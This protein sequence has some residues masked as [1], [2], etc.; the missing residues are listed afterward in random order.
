MK[1]F[2]KKKYSFF[3]KIPAGIFFFIFID[4][5]ATNFTPNSFLDKKNSYHLKTN[6]DIKSDNLPL[7][8]FEDK[9]TTLP[10]HKKE[11]SL[12]GNIS[13]D[14]YYNF[15]S[16]KIG[17]LKE[18]SLNINMN[19]GFIQTWYHANRDFDTLLHTSNIGQSVFSKQ[20]EASLNYYEVEGLY[21]QKIFYPKKDNFLSLKLKLLKGKEFQNLD[22]KGTNTNNRFQTSFDYYY[23]DKNYISKN[24]KNSDY[25]ANGYGIDLEYIYTSQNF[26]THIGLYNIFGYLY[27]DGITKMH[28]DLDSQTIYI[29]EDGF[30][31]QKPFGVGYYKYNT[32]Y[33]QKLNR[34]S[35][36]DLA[37]SLNEHFILSN[38]I[39]IHE[40]NI[41]NN[42]AILYKNYN[43]FYKI[44]YIKELE[45]TNIG[46]YFENISFELFNSFNLKDNLLLLNLH[47]T[48]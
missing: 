7:D 14:T 16:F 22:V 8:T 43:N 38:T 26:Y 9:W 36:I 5:Y 33:K 21:L 39:D 47:F 46:L 15:D 20:I 24:N 32:K 11:N 40:N 3:K 30:N 34:Y 31:H 17:L 44:G 42:M 45:K 18:Y 6:I 2:F 37:Y 25:N 23:S 12:F 1:H 13:L 48:F 35:K 10:I 28:Y 29:G 4:L 19:S 41:Y 27:W